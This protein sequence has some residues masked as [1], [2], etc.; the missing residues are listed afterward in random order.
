MQERDTHGYMQ[1][2]AALFDVVENRI[3]VVGHAG[4]HGGFAS[5]TRPL[6]ARRQTETPAETI[7]SSTLLVGGTVTVT[8]VRAS[9]TSNEALLAGAACSRGDEPFRAEPSGRPGGA[10]D[11]DRVEQSLRPQTY[12]LADAV[13]ASAIRGDR[14]ST[15]PSS[16]ATTTTLS[17]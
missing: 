16:R 15:P 9:S 11:L 13:A 4:E 2:A 14:S 3:T 8:P 7:A 10:L 1:S 12:T 5:P 17:P 6:V